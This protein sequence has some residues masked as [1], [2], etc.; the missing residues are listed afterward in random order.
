MANGGA[1]GSMVSSAS[2]RSV[3]QRTSDNARAMGRADETMLF[4]AR[5]EGDELRTLTS[6]GMPF[7]MTR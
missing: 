2:R 5:D 4:A 7:C 3:E 1:S 6:S